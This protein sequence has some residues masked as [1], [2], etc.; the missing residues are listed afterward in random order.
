MSDTIRYGDLTF[1][2][3]EIVG[4]EAYSTLSLLCDALEIGTLTV[5]LRVT[6]A[7]RGA[8]L[9]SF[10]RNE[11][12]LH[13]HGE[14]L[15]GTYYLQSVTRTGRATYELSAGDAL[16]LLDQSSHMGGIYTGETV[17]E[18]VADIC[19]IPAVVQSKFA[20]IR[21]YGWL[22]VAKRRENLTQVLFAVGASARVDRH[23]TL[24]IEGLWDGV[25]SVLGPER[26]F[27]GDSISYAGRTTQVSVLEHQYIPGEEEIT[28]F[29]GTAL[30]GDVV[31]FPEPAHTLT[32]EGFSIREQGANFAR[33]SAGSGTLKG[34]KYIHTTREVTAAVAEDDVPNV[35]EVTDATLVSL[36][37]SAAVAQRL[38]AY[39]QH[40]ETMENTVLSVGERP[41][42]V[43]AFQHPFGGEAVGCV[44]GTS[45]SF[46]GR[47]VADE[48][49]AVGYVPPQAN[50][51]YYD[52]V[53]V[54]T[55]DTVWTVPA[56][57]TS[58]RAVLI[59]GGTG[60]SSGLPGE[61]SDSQT[62]SS[63]SDEVTDSISYKTLAMMVKPGDGGKPG[64][65]GEGGKI[66]QITLDVTPG[67]IF[68]VRIGVGGP[69][70]EPGEASDP[71]RSGT[72]T[73]FG[74]HS[75]A[76]GSASGS[77]FLEEV[78]GHRYAMPGEAG[79]AGGMGS[80]YDAETDQ[81]ITG[82]DIVVNDVHYKPGANDLD[83]IEKEA[84]VYDR[85]YGHRLARAIGGYGGGAAFRANGAPGAPA[86]T[87]SV[88]IDS[89]SARG[90]PGG[91][92]ADAQPPDDQVQIGWGGTGGNGGGGGGSPG[93]ALCRNVLYKNIPGGSTLSRAEL[94]VYPG[95]PG[96]GGSGS[97]G[98]QAA[99]GG[100][101]LY[102][103]RPK[104]VESGQVRDRA[105]RMLLDRQG[106]RII[107]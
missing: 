43:V 8:A 69:G 39:Y 17:A 104:K 93:G 73:T 51:G 13:Y 7:A 64:E 59:G 1:T 31:Q 75:S 100:V 88:D 46:G 97:R 34:K 42:D 86:A 79:V 30:E 71:G 89:A 37:N 61:P 63:S 23:G 41:G 12:L 90:G 10:R 40:L 80:G 22:P 3:D 29:E 84:G 99:S 6:E 66:Y 103:S 94:H 68:P 24:R 9:T 65:P 45:V 92:G 36:V 54:L 48:T 95:T 2:E 102:Y 38:A 15:R 91:A 76:S 11:K 49:T 82:P 20:S 19:N 21:L 26:V 50:A 77:G 107:V 67:E 5:E 18:L 35:A 98:G 47:L 56:G 70:G 52:A 33:L 81:E 14:E 106:R 60:G 101:I 96:P 32:A 44:A 27:L 58:V 28:L 4:G 105:G 85:D 53:E 83:R 55:A 74:S 62:V 78:F 72:D 57:V 16:A 25:A 87:A